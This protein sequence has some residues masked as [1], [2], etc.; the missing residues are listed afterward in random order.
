MSE[1]AAA[2]SRRRRWL[3]WGLVASLA[4]NLFFV[5]L[6]GATAWRWHNRQAMG[7]GPG[8]AWM[9]PLLPEEIR[10][11]LRER[12][13]QRRLDMRERGLEMR[14]AQLVV[15]RALATEPYD[16]AAVERAFAELRQR[17]AKGQELMHATI[18]AA[19]ADLT[20]EQ[21]KAMIDRLPN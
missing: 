16:K 15:L 10:S 17:L 9:A 20:P 18:A 6:I 19:A 3:G 4:F 1:P 11:Q 21:R 8:A 5:G 7:F 13:Q 14:Q 12:M 2:P